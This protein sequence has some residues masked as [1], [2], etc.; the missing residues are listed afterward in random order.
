MIK[1]SF[2]R[3]HQN[4]RNAQDRGEKSRDDKLYQVI[5]CFERN[6]MH[7]ITEYF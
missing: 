1:I 4:R 3:P 5:I 6:S 7:H 2:G